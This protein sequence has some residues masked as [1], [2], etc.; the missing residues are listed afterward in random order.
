MHLLLDAFQHITATSIYLCVVL[1][2][3]TKFRGYVYKTVQFTSEIE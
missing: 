1:L 3:E 2:T